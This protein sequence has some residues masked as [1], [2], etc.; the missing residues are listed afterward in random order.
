MRICVLIFV[1]FA[2]CDYSG[3]TLSEY[4]GK[5]INQVI[6]FDD[7]IEIIPT[8]S[9][10]FP[11]SLSLPRSMHPIG[12]NLLFPDG[13]TDYV[14]HLYD[15]KNEILLAN[16][17]KRGEGPLE[18]TN[19]MGIHAVDN[20]IVGVDA[21]TRDV[22]VFSNVTGENEEMELID[23]LD[24]PFNSKT[25]KVLMIGQSLIGLTRGPHTIVKYDAVQNVHEG[26]NE[27]LSLELHDD[28]DSS[29]VYHAFF[30]GGILQPG[31]EDAVFNF[32]RYAPL[33]EKLPLNRT[34]SKRIT[35]MVGKGWDIEY[36]AHERGIGLKAT[37][38]RLGFID[39]SSNGNYIYAI[40]SG[41]VL[42]AKPGYS[43][44]GK[45]IFKIDRNTGDL[46]NTYKCDNGLSRIAVIKNILYAYNLNNS[47]KIYVFN[48]SG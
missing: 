13:R 17:L 36:H 29:F 28:L 45:F 2:S 42:V 8:D 47:E 5:E 20:G 22:L 25:S 34:N 43:R 7:F 15:P 48:L 23:R 46:V 19:L 40:Y 32:M 16:F 41:E 37:K 33:Y 18:V 26:L 39:A 1:L 21:R 27:S 11:E 35:T 4:Y 44:E 10:N 31:S 12:D 14:L 38:T 24:N 30:Q 6:T 3:S 9:I